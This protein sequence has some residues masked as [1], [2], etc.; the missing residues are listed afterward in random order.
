MGRNREAEEAREVSIYYSEIS[1]VFVRLMAD[2]RRRL[3]AAYNN[4]SMAR[5]LKM[6]AEEA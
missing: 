6:K 2:R 3:A 4:G 1:S 5:I